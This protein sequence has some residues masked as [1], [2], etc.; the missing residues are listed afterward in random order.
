MN[1][2]L[3]ASDNDFVTP[4]DREDNYFTALAMSFGRCF[5]FENTL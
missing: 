3:I 1:L 4:A 2:S 5:E